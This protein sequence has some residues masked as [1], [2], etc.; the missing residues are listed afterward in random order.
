MGENASTVSGGERQRIAIARALLHGAQILLLDES[1]SQ[2]DPQTASEIEHFVLDLEDITVLLVSH[3]ATDV[4]KQ[5]ADETLL[6]VDGNMKAI[7]KA[8]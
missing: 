4:A 7:D 8:C 2:L 1:T 6:I 5:M 3:H